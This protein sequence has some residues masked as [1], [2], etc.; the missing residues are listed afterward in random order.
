MRSGGGEDQIR[1]IKITDQGQ[2]LEV[3]KGIKKRAGRYGG[4]TGM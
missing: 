4:P 1:D 3:K 2:T